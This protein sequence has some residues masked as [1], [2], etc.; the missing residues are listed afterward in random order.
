M[1]NPNS[2]VLDAPARAYAY[3][4]EAEISKGTSTSTGTSITA[5]ATL[6]ADLSSFA[7][8]SGVAADVLTIQTKTG[9]GS[10]VTRATVNVTSLGWHESVT[11]TW[12]GT[13]SH[14][15][16]TT[17]AAKAIWTKN[18][19]NNS[20]PNSGNVE[21]TGVTLTNPAPSVTKPDAPT[22]VTISPTYFYRGQT[23][24]VSW[25]KPSGTVTGYNIRW[26][27]K[28]PGGSYSAWHT[29]SS[30][31]QTA[32]SISET[33]SNSMYESGST[34]QYQVQA[35]NTG[36]NSAWSSSATAYIAARISIKIGGTWY[37][38]IPWIKTT[39]GWKRGACVFIKNGGTWY[40]GR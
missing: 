36:G 2:I 40:R 9:S 8:G 7:N 14:T 5:T 10:W 20:S 39:D 13:I 21:T 19:G 34:V 23:M 12:T 3:I 18:S 26:R 6:T 32:T 11:A 17:V 38:G 29:H 27:Y 24:K 25:T 15:T 1:A 22:N 35:Y 31:G 4:L 33:W 16:T 30:S 37:Y 28:I